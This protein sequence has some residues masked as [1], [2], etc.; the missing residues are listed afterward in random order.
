MIDVRTEILLQSTLD[1]EVR[2]G[3][4]LGASAAVRC[5]GLGAWAGTGGWI[6]RD[7]TRRLP[8]AARFPVYSITKSI[9]AVC[10]LRLVEIGTLDLDADL[11]RWLP[12][13]PF[14]NDV[15]IRQLLRHT[16]GVSN[17]SLWPEQIAA[18]AASPERAW[19]LED[20]LGHC[21]GLPLDF[22]PDAGW[23]YSNTGY[24]LLK[25]VVELANGTSYAEAVR[26]HVA[27]PLGHR[28]TQV[29]EDRRAFEPLVPGYSRRL[30]GGEWEDVRGR[31]DPGWCATGVVSSTAAEICEFFTALFGGKLVQHDSLAE[32]IELVP[33]PD[34]HP[35]AVDPGYG[36]GLMGSRGPV[37]PGFGHGGA[38]PGYDLWAWLY[39]DM[40]H[41]KVSVAV[42]CNTD[43]A[44]AGPIAQ[45]LAAVLEGEL[46]GTIR[47]D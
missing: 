36:L 2:K 9:T 28:T 19:V 11:G 25:R 34:D 13:L 40:K 5:E 31:L 45:A 3:P 29:M 1:R 10:V 24:L 35:P 46:G 32:M 6:D 37:G 21:A 14:A 4:A 18:L 44:P 33:V 47:L 22:A 43:E 23:S 41:R 8:D 26:Q 7:Q 17:Y 30:T 38:G 39:T 15:T 16:A 20:F 12:D 27:G 42:F